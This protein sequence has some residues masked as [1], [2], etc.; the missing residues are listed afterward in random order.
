VGGEQGRRILESL[1]RSGERAS[2]ELQRVLRR[3]ATARRLD[4]DLADEA[5]QDAL[6]ELWARR[7][8]VRE[9]EAFAVTLFLR[10]ICDRRRREKRAGVCVVALDP[11]QNPG[12]SPATAEIDAWLREGLERVDRRTADLLWAKHVEGRSDRELAERFGLSPGSVAK[13]VSRAE[14]KYRRGLTRT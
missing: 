10:R 9:P 5:S 4:R 3:I 14:A 7:K 8:S 12:R 13:T 11:G 2:V 1:A 6:A